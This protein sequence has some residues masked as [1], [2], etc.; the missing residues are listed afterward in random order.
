MT[1]IPVVIGIKELNKI[2]IVK[3]LISPARL[4]R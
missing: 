3:T 1:S 4:K 2:I